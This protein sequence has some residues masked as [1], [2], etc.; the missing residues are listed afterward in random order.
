VVGVETMNRYFWEERLSGISIYKNNEI[1]THHS[2]TLMVGLHLK[3][4]YGF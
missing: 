4:P 2:V 1:L 3:A